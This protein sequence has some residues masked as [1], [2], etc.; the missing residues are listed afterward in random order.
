MATNEAIVARPGSS[1]ALRPW[2]F[3]S[4]A[5]RAAILLGQREIRTVFRTPAYLIPNLVIPIFFYFVMVASLEDFANQ[6][7]VQN[8][9]AF[10]LP[11][12]ILFAVQSGSAGMN[13]VADIESG[14]F[15]KLLLTPANRLS[16]LIGAMTADFFR[17]M[18][19]GVIVLVVALIAGL[20]FETGF[21]GM[22]VMITVLSVWGIAFSAIGFAIALRTGNVQATQSIWTL[23][24]PLMFLTTAFAPKEALADWLQ[25]AATLNPLTYVLTGMRSLSM[26]GWDGEALWQAFAA[27]AIFGSL[28]ITLAF[29]SLKAR[30]A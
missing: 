3:W 5:F 2:N 22:V 9:E 11:V 7:G 20:H 27:V 8:W 1:P 30:V 6:A 13:M 21:P 12:G 16:I 14:Y 23:F 18:S 19:Q 15:D 10:Q 29:M 28:T 17:I 26:F 24:I 4:E 25:V